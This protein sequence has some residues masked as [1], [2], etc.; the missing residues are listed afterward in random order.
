MLH[1]HLDHVGS[2]LRA[3][4]MQRGDE[5]ALG[6]DW[7]GSVFKQYLNDFCVAAVHGSV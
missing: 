7:R 6:V 4:Q 3:G 1:H 5:V 2:S